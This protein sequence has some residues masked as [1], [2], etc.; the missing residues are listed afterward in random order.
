MEQV[1]AF[2]DKEGGPGN[3]ALQPLGLADDEKRSLAIFLREGLKG[4]K[5]TFVY[6]RLPL[7]GPGTPPVRPPSGGPFGVRLFS[8]KPWRALFPWSSISRSVMVHLWAVGPHPDRSPTPLNGQNPWLPN[9]PKTC[10]PF[11]PISSS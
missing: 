9:I 3:T 5:T 8:Q 6:P 2:F 7:S 4:E 10:R 1:V 11:P